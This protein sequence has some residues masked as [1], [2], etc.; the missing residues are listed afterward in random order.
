MN[1][2]NSDEK[3]TRTSLNNKILFNII[4]TLSG[5]LLQVIEQLKTWMFCTGGL[6]LLL[7]RMEILL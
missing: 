5:F 4:I 2:H 7:F 6:L 1:I 3:Q